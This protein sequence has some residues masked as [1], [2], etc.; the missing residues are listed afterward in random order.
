ASSIPM[1][2]ALARLGTDAGPE[3]LRSSF[4]QLSNELVLGEPFAEAV[5]HW[6]DGLADPTADRVCAALV[7]HDEVGAERFGRCLDQLA[8]A[9]RTELALRE[10]VGSARAK[11]VFQARILLVLP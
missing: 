10:Q 8:S 4:R 6:A 9:L 5:Q 1:D 2:I 7:L 3:A 11:I